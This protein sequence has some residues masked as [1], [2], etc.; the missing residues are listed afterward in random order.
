M[1]ER[2]MEGL[3]A[4]GGGVF[5][6]LLGVFIYWYLWDFE[7]STDTTRSVHSLVAMLYNLG[8]KPLASAP[9][10]ILGILGMGK[11]AYHLATPGKS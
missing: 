11:G 6:C 9:F 10:V 5:L 1:N 4:A 3:K 8:G 7:N 2:Q